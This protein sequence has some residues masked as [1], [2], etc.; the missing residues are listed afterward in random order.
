MS[1][2]WN[3]GTTY[4][5]R[6]ASLAAALHKNPT[7]RVF[8]AN[9][10]YDL[11]TPFAAVEYTISHLS[12]SPAERDRLHFVRYEGGH[13]AYIAPQVRTRFAHDIQTFVTP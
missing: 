4:P 10:Y 7:L 5:D 9:G 12:L 3:R 1:V 2:R 6:G 13:A 8:L 11:S